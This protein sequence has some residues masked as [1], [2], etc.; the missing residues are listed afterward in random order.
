MSVG[1]T[2]TENL[3]SEGQNGESTSNVPVFPVVSLVLRSM[4][5][6]NAEHR[7][8]CTNTGATVYAW[9]DQR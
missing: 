4:T 7:S 8:F 1:G 2:R 9:T 3:A 5:C 6:T